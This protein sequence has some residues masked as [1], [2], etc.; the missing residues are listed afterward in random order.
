M[1]GGFYYGSNKWLVVKE[2]QVE[3]EKEPVWEGDMEQIQS[4]LQNRLQP[5]IGKKIWQVSFK[6]LMLTMRSEPRVG[7]VKILRLLPNRFFIQARSRKPLIV[8]LNEDNGKIHPLSVDGKILPALPFNKI[9]DLPIL[10]GR[11]LFK[12][13]ELRQKAI[14]FLR[15]MEEQGEFSQPEI[16]E[17]KYSAQEKSFIFILSSNGQPVKIGQQ[18]IKAKIKRIESVLRYLNQKNIKWHVMDA[19]FSQKIVVSAKKPI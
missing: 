17:I 15:I 18:A 7:E 5:F 1:G 4:L 19:R 2:I 9:P 16:S 14:Q 3:L 11:M 13:K 12:D 8:A 10:R 6:D